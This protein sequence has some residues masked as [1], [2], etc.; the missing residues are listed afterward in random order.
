MKTIVFA[1][2]L[3]AACTVLAAE[4]AATALVTVDVGRKT[5][6]DRPLEWALK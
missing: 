3:A 5:G 4:P 2:T 1:A 6:G